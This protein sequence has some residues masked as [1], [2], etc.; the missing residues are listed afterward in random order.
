MERP[1]IT[2]A[3]ARRVGTLHEGLRSTPESRIANV[4]LSIDELDAVGMTLVGV[5]NMGLYDGQLAALVMEV[6][7][8]LAKEKTRLSKELGF[9]PAEPSET[10][11]KLVLERGTGECGD[12][13]CDCGRYGE[14]LV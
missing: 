5:A 7:L 10:Y 9:D 2:E 11:K 12:D 3:E 4:P 13:D 8:R 14:D 1:L 6:A